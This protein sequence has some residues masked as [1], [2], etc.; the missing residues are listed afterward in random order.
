MNKLIGEGEVGRVLIGI[1]T[2][3]FLCLL[4]RVC[5]I[6]S[7]DS[8]DEGTRNHL[9]SILLFSAAKYVSPLLLKWHFKT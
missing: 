3:L 6:A 5:A 7:S 8:E 9:V 1:K 4:L 2:M